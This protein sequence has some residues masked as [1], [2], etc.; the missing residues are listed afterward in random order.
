MHPSALNYPGH[1]AAARGTFLYCPHQRTLLL[2]VGGRFPCF[3]GGDKQPQF[4]PLYNKAF[5]TQTRW[6]NIQLSVAEG[7]ETGFEY[8]K[9]GNAKMV[10]GRERMEDVISTRASVT[11]GE[12]MVVTQLPPTREGWSSGKEASWDPT[13]P[14]DT[15]KMGY[16]GPSL[17]HPPLAGKGQVGP[18]SPGRASPGTS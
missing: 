11:R 8:Q 5:Q 7:E 6:P 2:Q 12:T 13:A 4:L 10:Y 18:Q 16:P 1:Q 15:P 14:S 9:K 3:S 17:S